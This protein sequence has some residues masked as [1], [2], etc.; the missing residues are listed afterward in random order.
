MNDSFPRTSLR[1]STVD[2]TCPSL[3]MVKLDPL[4]DIER[5]SMPWSCCSWWLWSAAP[6]TISIEPTAEDQVWIEAMDR[7][8]I[9]MKP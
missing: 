5:C 3:V 2:G 8:K 4:R 9:R 7:R 6:W 1:N